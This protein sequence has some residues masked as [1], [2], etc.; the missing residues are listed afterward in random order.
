MAILSQPLLD[1]LLQ[2]F[3]LVFNEQHGLPPIWPYD[4]RIHLL[5]GI[6]PVVVRPYRYP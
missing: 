4:H 2:Q 3:G 5:P 6:T 1:Q